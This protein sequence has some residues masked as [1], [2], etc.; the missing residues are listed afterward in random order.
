[1]TASSYSQ[2]VIAATGMGMQIDAAHRIE[3]AQAVGVNLDV[4]TAVYE[5]DGAAGYPS[6]LART[7]CEAPSLADGTRKNM[8][9]ILTSRLGLDKTF[10]ESRLSRPLSGK[11]AS[12][13]R[14]ILD[15]HGYQLTTLTGLGIRDAVRAGKSRPEPNVVKV[16]LCTRFEA[17]GVYLGS[18]FYRYERISD[19]P[20]ELP[21]YCFGLEIAGDVIPL[22]TVLAMRD[23]GLQ[24]FARLDA[25]AMKTAS[26]GAK[27]RRE[28]S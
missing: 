17:D 25:A 24:D 10:P 19:G 12:V 13:V 27:T 22:K 21:W 8:A 16:E 7:L 11:A 23:I 20:K 15:E 28:R 9:E 2:Q 4:K 18:K 1:M 14:S 6:M 26:A 5:S 3:Q